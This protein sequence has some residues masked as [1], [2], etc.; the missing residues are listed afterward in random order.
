M[1][2]PRA[3]HAELREQAGA[4]RLHGLLAHWVEVM[5]HPEQARWV[6]QL[7]AWE[8]AERGQRSLERRLRAAHIGRFKPLAD[9]DWAWPKSIDRGAIE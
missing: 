3:S 6:A 4:L 2:E 8:A 7:L 5:G 9:F 1:N